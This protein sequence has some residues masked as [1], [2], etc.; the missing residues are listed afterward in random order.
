MATSLQKE[1]RVS[2]F[3]HKHDRDSAFLQTD[4]AMPNPC[5]DFVIQISGSDSV[6][7]LNREGAETDVSLVV[8]ELQ[9]C[10]KPGT[11][12]G[13][14]FRG[15]I[16]ITSIQWLSGPTLDS[17]VRAGVRLVGV[18]ARPSEPLE[19]APCAEELRAIIPS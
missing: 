2:E 11:E 5:T 17:S 10:L 12:I 7:Y 13:L 16:A 6:P 19:S 4:N 15:Y 3:L 8:A 9:R 14:V 1:K 18:S